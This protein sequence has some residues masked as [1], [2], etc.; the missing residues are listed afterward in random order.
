MSDLISLDNVLAL[1]E[2]KQ[3]ELCPAGRYGR[4]Y[5]YGTDREL[6]D[7]WQE[8]IDSIEKFPTINP[9]DLRPKGRWI[10]KET[11]IFHGYV[12]SECKKHIPMTNHLDYPGRFCRNC[13]AEME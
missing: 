9:E 8:L 1:I 12:C 11:L 6:Y 7:E 13:G 4:R 5:V 2:E 10:E 3:K